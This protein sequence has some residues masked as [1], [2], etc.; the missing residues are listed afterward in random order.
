ML[1]IVPLPMLLT[2]LTAADAGAVTITRADPA[3]LALT[4]KDRPLYVVRARSYGAEVHA[5]GRVRMLAG[6]TVLMDGLLMEQGRKIRKLPRVRQE[7][8]GRIVLTEGE[9]TAGP[10]ADPV[11]KLPELPGV[12][13]R[14]GPEEIEITAVGLPTEKDWPK[15]TAKIDLAGR[16]GDDALAVR[17]LRGG[18][19]DAL[20]ARYLCSRH[21]F[22][23]YGWY[24]HTWPEVEV[25]CADGTKLAIRGITGVSHYAV[26]KKD[27]QTHEALQGRRGFWM[28]RELSKLSRVVLTVR[29]GAAGAAIAPAPYATIRPDK[30]RGL[31]FEGEP[32]R[33]HLDFAESYLE[34]GRWRLDW[35]LEDHRQQPAGEGHTDID[36]AAGAAASVPVDITPKEMG[37]FRARLALSRP[38][39]PA[40]RRA[41][42]V[43]FARVRPEHPALRDLDGQRDVDEEMLWANL[44]GMRGLRFNPSWASNRRRYG[45]D[46]GAIDWAAWR[47]GFQRYLKPAEN[48]TVRGRSSFTGVDW[49]GDLAKWFEQKYPDEKLRAEAVAEAKRRYLTEYAREAGR[50]GVDAWEPV[51]EPDLS[52]PPEK[53]IEEVLKLQYPAVKAGNPQASFL[54]GSICGLEKHGWVRRLYE[55]GGQKWFDGTS[56]HPYTGLGFQEA[57]RAELDAWWQVLRDYGDANEGLWMTESAW[58]RGWGFNDYVYDRFGAFRQSQA[59]NAVLMHVHAE[60]MRIPRERIYVFYLCE[61]GYN[62]FYLVR[63]EH[64]TAAAVAIQVMNESLRDARFVEELPL[65]GQGHYFQLYRDE[66]RTV[67]VAF[68]AGE[69]AELTVATDAADVTAT[70]LMGNRRTLRPE[71]GRLRVAICGDP[72]YLVVPAGRAIRPAYDGLRVQPNLAIPTLGA[73]VEVSSVARPKKGPALPASAAISGDWT[74]YG[75]AGA[76]NGSRRGW[77]EAEDGKDTFPDTFEV[78]L[79]EPADVARVRVYHDYGAWERLLRDYDVQAHAGG[80]WRTVAEVRGNR[81]GFVQDHRFEPVRTDRV[82]LLIHAVNACLFESMTWIPKLSTLRAVEVHAAPGGP[83]RAFFLNELPR[84]RV[85]APGEATRLT[86]RLRNV[87]GKP[88]SGRVRLRLPECLRVAPAGREVSLAPDAQAECTFEV[89]L[90]ADAPEGLHTV[91][92]GL[93]DGEDLIS[94]DYAARVLCCKKPPAAK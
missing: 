82:R 94:A 42:E 39:R 32:V 48:G 73:T 12:A 52:M 71:G 81:Y 2:C 86:F 23:F 24:G 25:T 10:P 27:P 7:G 14:F 60:A 4:D 34:P 9:P 19:E 29:P 13:L 91:L 68:T 51:N 41:F 55:L 53:Y 15:N 22:S 31:F 61:H 36:L 47:E 84:R 66:A 40:A 89:R 79:G 37:F 33:F 83:A 58:H 28:L 88:V 64:P 65:P 18:A 17:D 44:L 5:D 70:D 93:Y 46:D 78:R 75:S 90:A 72:T 3:A 43:A 38:D 80:Q 67:A 11:A 6:K 20:P 76:W 50:F 49:H 35:R 56:F 21:I 8:D 63:R 54:G 87:T 69:D 74:C 1:L 62:D 59:R 16:L 92:A 45:R 57:Y 77:D 26:G 30:P 85:L